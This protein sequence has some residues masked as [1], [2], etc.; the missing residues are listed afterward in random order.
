MIKV[1]QHTRSRY[2][3]ASAA[4]YF[5]SAQMAEDLMEAPA[6]AFQRRI[7]LASLELVQEVRPE[8]QIF[9]E[10]LIQY[11][12]PQDEIGQ[13]VPDNMVVIHEE[14]LEV[15]GSFDMP[16]Q[17]AGPFWV[18][19]Y[20]SK[21]NRRKDYDVNMKKYAYLKVPYYLTFYPDD[22]ELSLFRLASRGR[23]YK[24]VLPNEHGRLAVSELQIEVG[25]LNGWARYWFRG[26]LL[27]LPGELQ[28]KLRETQKK[29]AD[30]LRQIESL[31]AELARRRG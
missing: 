9:N 22:E 19:E 24:S 2:R 11:P 29:L 6:Q 15:E 8:V 12:A 31:K 7:T 4:A 28:R 5:A 3:Y 13:V 26:E 17:P 18:F 20:V 1:E 27:P 16:F 30:A 10:L 14:P 25:I 21:Q 23:R